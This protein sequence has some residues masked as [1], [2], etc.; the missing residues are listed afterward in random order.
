MLNEATD[1]QLT[2]AMNELISQRAISEHAESN[3]F[4]DIFLMDFTMDR[5]NF[6]TIRIQ[7]SALRLITKSVKNRSVKD[8][9]K[10]WTLTPYGDIAMTRLRAIQRPSPL[11]ESTGA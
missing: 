9:A 3:D 10:Y 6:Q 8:T 7:L 2:R 4:K 11:E 5:D 1:G